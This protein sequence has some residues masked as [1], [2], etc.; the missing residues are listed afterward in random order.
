MEST[1]LYKD[2]TRPGIRY[3]FKDGGRLVDLTGATITFSM[4]RAVDSTL[5]VDNEAA[6]LDGTNPKTGKVIYL[7]GTADVDTVDQYVGWFV[8]D[9]GGGEIFTG[10]EFLI[11]IDA[12]S[13]GDGVEFGSIAD[14]VQGILTV[15][16]NRLSQWEGFGDR[17]IQDTIEVVKFRVLNTVVP[18]DNEAGLNLLVQSYVAKKVALE[19]IPACRD[20]WMS[21]VQ[22]ESSNEPNASESYPD[23][24][25]ALTKLQ[26]DLL[27]QIAED[28]LEVLPLLPS[29]TAQGPAPL[30]SE[31]EIARVT[32]S[33][34]DFP[35]YDDFPSDP[36]KTSG[37][38]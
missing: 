7:P 23:R 3:T 5:K 24:I 16:F 13:P 31:K 29:S 15:T 18:V 32:T 1:R 6:V 21:Q 38:L 26:E 20:Y 35:T 36:R 9:F 30:S 8:A 28:E 33:P 25:A 4:R 34:N 27:R 11:F 22:A 17:R 37:V 2:A 10:Q 14:R 19:L 12:H